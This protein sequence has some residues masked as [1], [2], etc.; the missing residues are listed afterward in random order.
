MSRLTTRRV[1]VTGMGI[2]SPVGIGLVDSWSNITAGKSG[3]GKITRFDASGY[4]SQIAGEVKGFEA[5]R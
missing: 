3:I 5:G 1:V 2:I 4:T